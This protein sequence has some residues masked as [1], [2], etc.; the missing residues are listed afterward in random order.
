MDFDKVSGTVL[1]IDSD[2]L[3]HFA[4]RQNFDLSELEK[5]AEE[6]FR[7]RYIGAGLTDILYNIDGNMPSKCR[8]WRGSQYLLKEENG[9]PVDWSE[10]VPLRVCH[11]ICTVH[12]AD[13]FK[14]WIRLCRENSINPW[15]SFR[16]NDVHYANAPTGHSQFFYKAKENGWFIGDKAAYRWEHVGASAPW[17][18]YALNYAVP[19]VRKYF[20]D[21]IDEMLDRY[22]VYGIELDWQRVIWCFER[23]SAD[24]C[25]YINELMET[26][27]GIV[28]KYEAK[29]GHS[30]K[31]M[32]RINRDIDENLLFGFDVR[33]WAK[34]D[35]IDVVVPSPYWGST[36][37]DMPIAKWKKEL[38]QTGIE[39]YAGLEMHTVHWRYNQTRET[40]A[41]QAAMYLSAG[42]D[43]I[44]LFNFMEWENE[45]WELC[46]SFKKALECPKRRYIVTQ[47]NCCPEG[48][49]RYVPLPLCMEEGGRGELILNHGMLNTKEATALYIGVN[50]ADDVPVVSLNGVVLKCVGESD[51]SYFGADGKTYPIL[52]Y[53]VPSN[54]LSIA[55]R[56]EITAVKA[57]S[58]NYVELVN[59]IL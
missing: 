56:I 7:Q 24:N 1:N 45:Y 18:Q 29:Y 47:S 11:E 35:W 52:A 8:D 39:V 49:K 59:G 28:A 30:I 5:K 10:S 17:Y 37:S 26:V 13:L 25:K 50:S 22:D 4:R 23:D 31:I 9:V 2:V 51:G 38:C 33:Y 43:K 57:V 3:Y 32:A 48:M 58:V 19:E 55:A 34:R 41:A 16:M 54:A 44:Y 20:T 15:L 6:Y 12:G 40:L 46:S 21:Y 53:N 27:N 36:D 42:A 14:I